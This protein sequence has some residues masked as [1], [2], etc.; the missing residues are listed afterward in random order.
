[1]VWRKDVMIKE[2]AVREGVGGVQRA[3]ALQRTR[4]LVADIGPEAKLL[5]RTSRRTAPW[6]QG[7]QNPR[8]REGSCHNLCIV[9]EIVCLALE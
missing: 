4:P 8:S 3:Y 9:Y 5:A 6:T 7:V 2:I 1:V